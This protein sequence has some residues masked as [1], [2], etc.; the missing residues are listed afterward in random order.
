MRRP[1]RKRLDFSLLYFHALQ[2]SDLHW[3]EE[4]KIEEATRE[5]TVFLYCADRYGYLGISDSELRKS[6]NPIPETSRQKGDFGGDLHVSPGEFR[7]LPRRL[8]RMEKFHSTQSVAQRL[9]RQAAERA[10]REVSI[11]E[12]PST[13]PAVFFFCFD[14][15]EY[16]SQSKYD[17][18]IFWV[19]VQAI[20]LFV[21]DI[22]H[23][24]AR[25]CQ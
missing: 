3:T 23:I 17:K 5:T 10:W 25:I 18:S 21:I 6:R 2:L 8:R 11:F 4:T 16:F 15:H 24:D 14:L 19:V 12:V 1:K 20:R 9:L 22:L 7:L 13:I